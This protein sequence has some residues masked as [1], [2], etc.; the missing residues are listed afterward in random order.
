MS[1]PTSARLLAERKRNM[2][3]VL[4]GEVTASALATYFRDGT[5]KESA[6]QVTSP[7]IRSDPSVPDDL[8][9]MLSRFS[10]LSSH[11]ASFWTCFSFIFL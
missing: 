4:F 1:G 10:Q 11:V 3:Q 2:G 5:W 7:P 6:A 8:M 9:K